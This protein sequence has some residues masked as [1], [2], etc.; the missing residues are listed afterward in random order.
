MA[1]GLPP[2]SQVLVD[3]AQRLSAIGVLAQMWAYLAS[4]TVGAGSG[5]GAGAGVGLSSPTGVPP[6]RASATPA[7][8][9]EEIA[10]AARAALRAM[11]SFGLEVVSTLRF[12]GGLRSFNAYG[13]S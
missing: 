12:K 6:P 9:I 8:A 13:V 4:L 10:R 7:I 1:R 3:L 5:V 2:D 11:R